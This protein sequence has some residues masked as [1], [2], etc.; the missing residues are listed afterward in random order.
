MSKA[1][2]FLK[3]AAA[4]ACV[5]WSLTTTPAMA[6]DVT[7]KF[8]TINSDTTRAFKDVQ[9]PLARAIEKQ[10]DGH[11]KVDLR[12][13]GPNGFGK[14]A[15]LFDMVQRG[16]IDIAYTVQGYSPGRFPATSVAEL[17]LIFRDS[18]EGT[19]V[20][21]QLYKE[22]L[23]G[24]EYDGLKVLSLYA[25]VPSGIFS[26]TKPIAA[27]KD[28]R[29]MRLRVASPTVGLSLAR[30]GA[31]PIGLPI[32]LIGE[33]IANHMV[34]GLAFGADSMETLPGVNGKGVADQVKAFYDCGFA[35][36]ALMVVMNQKAYDA[37]PK[38][39]QKVLDDQFG[40]VEMQAM[41][42]DRDVNEDAAKKRLKSVSGFAYTTMTPDQH[43]EMV[44]LIAPVLDDWK[45]AMADKSIDGDK[46]LKRAQE[47][48]A[49]KTASAN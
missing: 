15:E 3:I 47:L 29:G 4:T 27:L 12:G 33:S 48:A 36:V 49:Q 44:K 7:L 10:S 13:A 11:I 42:K 23:L 46:L 2:T 5:A 17:P 1:S 34:D 6:Q 32:N 8:A 9:Q 14:P 21:W 19:R 35:E 39:L 24:K 22:G 38:E 30:L 18:Q 41:A 16:D 28:L 43:D 31:V 25:G 26:A 37:M 20:L 45:K 40:V